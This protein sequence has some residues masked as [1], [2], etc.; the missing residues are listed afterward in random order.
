[1]GGAFDGGVEHGARGKACPV[2]ATPT[3]ARPHHGDLL[4]DPIRGHRLLGG[5]IN[6]YR[7]AA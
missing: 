6:E 4:D 7:R 1:M 5:V 2:R 3:T